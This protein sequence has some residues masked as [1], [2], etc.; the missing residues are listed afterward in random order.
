MPKNFN[1]GGANVNCIVFSISKSTCSL[2]VCK[3]A[4][5]FYIL[6]LYPATLLQ[7]LISSIEGFLGFFFFLSLL[8]FLR[9]Q[10]CHLQT[11][12]VLFLPSQSVYLLFLNALAMTSSMVLKKSGERGH[13]CF[14]PDLR[15][16]ASSFSPFSMMLAVCFLVDVLYQVDELPRYS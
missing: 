14:V 5:N 6:T 11:K 1:F 9:K 10:S 4:I 15:G 16:K 7:M 2:L 3:K 8:D 12:T 13:V